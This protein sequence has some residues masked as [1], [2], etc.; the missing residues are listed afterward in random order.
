MRIAKKY[1]IILLI[2]MGLSSAQN[3]FCSNEEDL[4]PLAVG[5][6]WIYKVNAKSVNVSSTLTETIIGTEIIDG[7]RVYIVENKNNISNFV[8]KKSYFYKENGQV[9]LAKMTTYQIAHRG[10]VFGTKEMQKVGDIIENN[11]P[12]MPVIQLQYPLKA[13]QL[14]L[15]QG[16]TFTVIGKESISVPAGT[17]DCWK[18]KLEFESE[19]GV[20]YRYYS[21]KVGL[22]KDETI[23]PE[24]SFGGSVSEFGRI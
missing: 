19:P 11:I 2:A 13:G 6:Y 16:G 10:V 24:D 15:S 12:G 18:I 23:S 9:I 3:I 20:I 7:R 4:F 8:N 5:N 17:F 21:D 22:V 1:L 14:W